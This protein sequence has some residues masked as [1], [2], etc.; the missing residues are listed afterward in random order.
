[1]SL[2]DNEIDSICRVFKHK[3]ELMCKTV[4]ITGATGLIG[5]YI[6]KTLL[7]LD[8]SI[9]VVAVVRSLEKAYSKGFNGNI[10]F[11]VS[12]LTDEIKYDKKVDYIIH[13]ASP[14]DS[15]YF[16]EKPVEL[17]NE[18]YIGL[19]N[20]LKFAIK[21]KVHG[22][23]FLSSLEVYGICNDDVFLKENQ[24]YSIDCN[25]IRN[26]YAEGKKA[27]ECLACSYASEYDVNAKIVRLCQTFGP[28]VSYNDN[29]VFA[30]FARSVVEK[31]DIVLATKGETKRTYCSMR[32]AVLGIL[33]VL[34]KG[35][36]GEAYNLASDN[37]YY[38]IYELAQMFSKNSNSKVIIME[39]E[40]AR[41]LKT[42]RFGLDTGKIKS[43]GFKSYDN[44]ES[45]VE[46][47]LDYFKEQIECE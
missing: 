35:V 21:N 43:I 41:Y 36:K 18:T 8:S 1:M 5:T 46:S 39:K 9:R 12:T 44:L 6:V 23:V 33:L 16:I 42:I 37:S 2:I 7:S 10:E 29:R 20:V 26:S 15:K 3:K 13:T 19:N 25:N 14:T 4:L 28:G 45:I 22:F 11:I 30:Q 38:S 40:D 34:I 17:M 32:D 47:C 24:Y 31:K 27:L